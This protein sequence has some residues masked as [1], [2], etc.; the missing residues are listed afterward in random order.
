MIARPLHDR[1]FTPFNAHH[2]FS[3]RNLLLNYEVNWT[4]CSPSSN[5]LHSTACSLAGHNKWSK[6]KRKKAIAD[7]ERA[8]IITKYTAQITTAVRLGGSDAD[9]NLRLASLL[10]TARAAGMAKANIESAVKAGSSRQQAS[11]SAAAEF[12][13]YEGRGAPGYYLLIE[14]LTNNRLRTR[15]ELRTILE[16][17]GAN[18]GEAGSASF[19]FEHKGVVR[20]SRQHLTTAS[21]EGGPVCDPLELAIAVGAEDV[22]SSERCAEDSETE[23]TLLQFVCAP[24]QLRAVSEGVAER[25]L[26]IVSAG[27]EYLPKSVVGLEAESFEKAL[28]LCEL[29][30]EHGDVMEIHH[31]FSVREC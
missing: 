31:N 11:G 28:R 23:D 18:L 16:K 14:T 15:P 20:V 17:N 30:S 1:N 13:M 25:G 6:I 7:L 4:S 22:S 12:I 8:K 26:T 27:L 3:V 24:A 9:T 5:L 2:T 10:S 19:M 21:A 29:I